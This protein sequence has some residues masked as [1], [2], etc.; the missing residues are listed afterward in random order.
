MAN[1][2]INLVAWKECVD[3]TFGE[4]ARLDTNG[5]L[6]LPEDYS[7][8]NALQA[9]FLILQETKDRNKNLA[10]SVCSLESIKSALLKMCTMGLNP[11]RKQAYFIV[12]GGVLECQ[13][14][15]F[16]NM[17]TAKRFNPEVKE[18]NA[19]VI[20]KNDALTFKIVG[21]KKQIEN[22]E[23][24]FNASETD[25]IVG[26]Y[27][28]VSGHRGE[29]INTVIM[30]INEIHASWKM[31]KANP[32]DNGKLKSGSVHAK[33]TEAMACR[34][35]INKAC[36]PLIN[37]ASDAAIMLESV[38]NVEVEVAREQMDFIVDKNA[39]TTKID[40]Q[41]G[42]PIASVEKEGESVDET[43]DPEDGF[44]EDFAA[45]VEKEGA[46]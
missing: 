10:L 26:A 11:Q 31:S 35:V 18:F 30:T 15:Y 23:Q 29:H 43:F 34:T 6:N 1:N 27:C 16:G 3:S 5:G 9:A 14:S 46:Q 45:Q 25:E 13:V 12:Y 8:A 20:Y 22:H 33:F 21:G 19:Q 17:S 7:V 4:I 44:E 38:A 39:N 2:E 28:V 24:A 42:A 32:F 41:E 36:K 40:F 37:S